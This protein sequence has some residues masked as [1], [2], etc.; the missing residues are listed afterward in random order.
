MFGSQML[1]AP[2]VQIEDEE[3]T[4]VFLPKLNIEKILYDRYVERGRTTTL[5]VYLPGGGWYRF[6][7]AEKTMVE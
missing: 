6:Q 5:Q 1:V 2:K 4:E 3:M 7:S